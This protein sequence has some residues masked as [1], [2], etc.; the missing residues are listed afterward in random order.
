MSNWRRSGVPS[1]DVSVQFWVKRHGDDEG[2]VI[3]ILTLL[4]SFFMFEKGH[5]P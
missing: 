1:M 2:I 4:D 3:T 5:S